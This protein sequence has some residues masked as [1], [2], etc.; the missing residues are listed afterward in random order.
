MNR[1]MVVLLS[2]SLVV[3]GC[4][5]I[6]PH[7]A[8]P[9]A[10]KAQVDEQGGFSDD[11]AFLRA[12]TDVLILKDR[13]GKGQVAVL[14][15]MQGRVM[16]STATDPKGLSFGWVNRE[17]IA[18]GQFAKHINVFGGEDRFWLGPE[19]G[20]FSIFFEKGVP[21]ELDHWFTPASVD[22]ESWTLASQSAHSTKLQKTIKVTNYSGTV[23]DLRVDREVKVLDRG[24]ALEMLGAT[25]GPG[26]DMV[27]FESNNKVVN[28]GSQPWTKETGLLSIWILGMFNPSPETTIAIPFKAG[29]ESELGPIVNDAYF[30]KVPEDRLV[31]KDGVLFF[32]ADG[33]Y[34]SKIGLSPQRAMKV[35]GSYDAANHVLTVV[36]YDKPE[37][38]A[39][40]VN[41]MWELQEHPFKGDVVNSYNDGPASPGAEPMGPFYE[42]ET[43]SPAAALTPGASVV[44]THRTFHFVGEESQLDAIAKT[45][46]GVGIAEI[47]SALP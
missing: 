30:G 24:V 1:K 18:S 34:R 38:A 31:I 47:K 3:A 33:Q 39:D 43:S 29:E 27:A 22:T 12:Y 20:Q 28:T 36:Q 46:L 42:L 13:S 2:I 6:R 7:K 35:A 25:A 11:V 9:A 21:F 5:T 37:G 8:T 23:F 15:K 17:L 32:S 16:T 14:P 40:Y 44:H 45:T 4:E 26:V 41:S 10:N 19:G